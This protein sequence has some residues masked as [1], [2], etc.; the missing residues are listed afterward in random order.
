MTESGEDVKTFRGAFK[1]L[2]AHDCVRFSRLAETGQYA[3]IFA[4]IAFW[5]GIGI[6]VLCRLFYPVKDKEAPLRTAG[7]FLRTFLVVLFQVCLSA[8]SVFYIRKIGQLFPLFINVC[9]SRYVP[10]H[11]VP[12][13]VGEIALALVFVGSMGTLVMQLDKMRSF[14]TNEPI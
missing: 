13:R 1:S 2:V 11:N 5:V 12:E 3:L 6:D 9:P 4:F 7:Q 10:G 8:I 14:I